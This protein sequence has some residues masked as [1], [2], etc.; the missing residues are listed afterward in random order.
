[1]HRDIKPENI[2]IHNGVYKIADFGFARYDVNVSLNEEKTLKRCTP[3]YGAP[4]LF[5]LDGPH[6]S[7]TN[8]CDMWSLGIIFHELVFGEKPYSK[9]T[10]NYS[11]LI[12]ELL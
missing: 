12:G 2:L 7:Y 8:L 3:I 10:T 1:M 5:G 9:D 11:K 4:Q 6:I